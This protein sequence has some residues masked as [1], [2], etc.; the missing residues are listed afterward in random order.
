MKTRTF[1]IT[2]T[3]CYILVVTLSTQD[4]TKLLQQLKS[5]LKRSINWN[6]YQSKVSIGAQNQYLYYLI[7]A[8][9]QVVNRLFVL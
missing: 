1:A 9:F 2:D 3:K 5:R 8:S 7:D 6:N 4:N